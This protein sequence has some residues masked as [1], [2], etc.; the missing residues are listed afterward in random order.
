MTF[1]FLEDMDREIKKRQTLRNGLASKSLHT[2]FIPYTL[3]SM[4]E[5]L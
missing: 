1:F 4:D 5:S 3:E 2:L